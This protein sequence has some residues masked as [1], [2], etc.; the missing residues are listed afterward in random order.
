MK[1]K[2]LAELT[3]IKALEAEALTRVIEAGD[4]QLRRTFDMYLE[5][6]DKVNGHGRERTRHETG[7]EN[8][9]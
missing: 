6:L 5:L 2:D 4:I 7:I 1:Q 8:N 9:V 3:I